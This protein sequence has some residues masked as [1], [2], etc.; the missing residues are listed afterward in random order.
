MKSKYPGTD[1]SEIYDDFAR[2]ELD[3]IVLHS[4]QPEVAAPAWSFIR[5]V[6]AAAASLEQTMEI[7]AS[8]EAARQAAEAFKQAN[9][10][11]DLVQA[12]LMRTRPT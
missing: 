1:F 9:D 11:Q 7:Q 8:E 2:G 3:N 10:K 12:G 4:A 6:V 5:K